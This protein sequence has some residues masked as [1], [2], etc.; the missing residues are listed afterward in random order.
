[1]TSKFPTDFMLVIP[2]LAGNIVTET[3]KVTGPGE[4]ITHLVHAIRLNERA[5]EAK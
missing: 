2:A 5:A 3:H 1:M 4:T